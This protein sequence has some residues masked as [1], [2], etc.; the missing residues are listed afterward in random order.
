MTGLYDRLSMY[1]SARPIFSEIRASGIEVETASEGISAMDVRYATGSR[2]LLTWLASQ[3]SAESG[4]RSAERGGAIDDALEAYV[5]DLFGHEPRTTVAEPGGGSPGRGRSCRRVCL[6][7]P[8]AGFVHL[9][10]YQEQFKPD[11]R[12]EECFWRVFPI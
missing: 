4:E 12:L 10:R 8:R 1:S 6:V 2:M 9:G 11:D 3:R 5:A 7:F